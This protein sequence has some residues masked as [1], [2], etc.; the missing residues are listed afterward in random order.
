ML[1][2]IVE[3]VGCRQWSVKCGV[4]SVECREWSVEC[5]VRSVECGVRIVECEVWGV[6]LRGG[7]LVEGVL[8]RRPH[9][10]LV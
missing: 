8:V 10:I 3:G 1:V 7:A 6:R 2:L 9:Q 4:W 5:G